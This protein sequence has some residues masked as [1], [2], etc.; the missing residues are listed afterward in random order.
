[1]TLKEKL[2]EALGD[3]MTPADNVTIERSYHIFQLRHTWFPWAN[4]CIVSC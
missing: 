4:Q 1:M 3:D 2:I